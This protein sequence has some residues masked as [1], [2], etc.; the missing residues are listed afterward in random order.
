M[1]RAAFATLLGAATALCSAVPALAQG[2]V[3][4]PPPA[5]TPA[6]APA[7][8]PGKLALSVAGGITSHGR[9]YVLSGDAVTLS[10]KVTP[11]VA[12]QTVRIRISAP[13]RKPARAQATV[14]K[15]GVFT[16]RFHTRRAAKY[17]VYVSHPAT[18]QQAAFSSRT[19][20]S[21]VSQGSGIAVALLKQGMRALGYPAGSGPAVTSKLGRELLAFRKVNDMARIY[22]A[23]HHI[24]E[25]VFAGQGAFK[26]RY[27]TAGKH[28]EADLSKQ[29]IVLADKGRPVGTY[30]TSSGKPSTP[31]VLGH[32]HFYLKAPG[33][34]AKGMYMSNYFIRGY[35]IHGYPEVPTYNA[36]HGCLRISNADAVS[37]FNQIDLGESIWVYP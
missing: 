37:V 36:S 29:V 21:A 20:A 32:Y 3:P 16:T 18:P 35:A 17:T 13:H 27:P 12:G 6:P 15:G 30:P 4:T 22:S 1:R 23:D 26:L 5:P 24:Y 9:L 33:T 19:S 25:M 34:N 11:Y 31:T 2:P 7:P 28:V 10:G 14:G 8:Q